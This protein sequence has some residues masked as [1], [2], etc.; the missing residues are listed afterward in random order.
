MSQKILLTVLLLAESGHQVLMLLQVVRPDLSGLALT[1]PM[2]GITSLATSA[3]ALVA[4]FFLARILSQRRAM[5]ETLRRERDFADVDALASYRFETR[6]TVC[7]RGRHWHLDTQWPPAIAVGHDDDAP[8]VVERSGHIAAV[9][10][11]GT[12]VPETITVFAQRWAESKVV[13][14]RRQHLIDQTR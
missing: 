9:T 8:A 10:F 6:P 4:M 5:E 14:D 12:A 1:E 7:L 13:H 2:A 11:I 3:A